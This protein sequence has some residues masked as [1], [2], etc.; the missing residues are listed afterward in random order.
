MS[1]TD[2]ANKVI[3]M[4]TLLG[5]WVSVLLIGGIGGWFLH[6]LFF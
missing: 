5:P 2:E 1:D 3:K 4:I 6:A